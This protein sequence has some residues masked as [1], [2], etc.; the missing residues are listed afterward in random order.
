MEWH[1]VLEM[2]SIANIDM[3]NV[4]HLIIDFR[5]WDT[6]NKTSIMTNDG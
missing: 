2:L 6:M 3:E 5:R 1:K 4:L